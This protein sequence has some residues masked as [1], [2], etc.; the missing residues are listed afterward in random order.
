MGEDKFITALATL[1]HQSFKDYPNDN[2]TES[3]PMFWSCLQCILIP[4]KLQNTIQWKAMSLRVEQIIFRKR[5]LLK[6]ICETDQIY[7]YG[8]V[9]H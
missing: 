7:F 2:T 8:S 1:F 4:P 6:S 3:A 9:Y 5:K